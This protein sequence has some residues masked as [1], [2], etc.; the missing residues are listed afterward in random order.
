LPTRSSKKDLYPNMYDVSVGE[1]LQVQETY[2]DGVIRGFMEEQE[3]DI[4]SDDLTMV[5]DSIKTIS[6]TQSEIV[7]WYYYVDHGSNYGCTEA[8]SQKWVELNDLE[9][10]YGN[11]RLDLLPNFK[12]VINEIMEKKMTEKKFTIYRDV[13]AKKTYFINSLCKNLVRQFNVDEFKYGVVIEK[14]KGVEM[15]PMEDFLKTDHEIAKFLAP[16]TKDLIHTEIIKNENNEPVDRVLAHLIGDMEYDKKTYRQKSVHSI[17]IANYK[18][19]KYVFSQWKKNRFDL[20]LVSGHQKYGED[21][22]LEKETQEETGI[23]IPFERFNFLGSVRVSEEEIAHAKVNAETVDMYVVEITE[24]EIYKIQSGLED[25]NVF[26]LINVKDLV[27]LAKGGVISPEFVINKGIHSVE[28]KLKWSMSNID[29]MLRAGVKEGDGYID[30]VRK[31][32]F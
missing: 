24:S 7:S 9:K 15:I 26:Y 32:I 5:I 12:V 8:A 28:E 23:H 19:E 20:A 13:E 16:N 3:F 30:R 29:N 25:S 18:G 11:M 6:D 27:A 1:H 21:R 31:S 17:G 10:I 22:N 14:P 2:L 4:N